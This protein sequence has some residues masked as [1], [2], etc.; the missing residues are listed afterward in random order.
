MPVKFENF[1]YSYTNSKGKPVFVPT[2]DGRRIGQQVKKL[3]EH[4][5]TFD[6]FYR[7]F[8]AGAHVAALHGHREHKWFARI[9]LKNF[10]YNISRQRV[11]RVLRGCGISRHE[12]F[13]KW[14]TVK[15]PVE[16]GSGYVL[17]Y[18]FVQSPILASLVLSESDLGRKLRNLPETVVVGVYLDDIS[19]S[20][21]DE[22]LLVETFEQIVALVEPSGFLINL[23]K[24]EP[25]AS[26]ISLFNCDLRMGY[27]SVTNERIAAF[28]AVTHS[29]QS[30]AGFEAYCVSVGRGNIPPS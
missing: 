4:S 15:T 11:Q 17:P 27:C 26:N 19:V 21:D 7:H 6:R 13:A 2:P 23:D 10:F 12:H 28:A 1:S 8:Q 29:D 22:T 18:G 9:D 20:S 24:T 3:V 5:Y 16:G 25:P 30:E 14:S